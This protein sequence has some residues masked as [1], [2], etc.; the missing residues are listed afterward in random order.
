MTGARVVADDELVWWALTVPIPETGHRVG[1]DRLS[2]ILIALALHANSDRIAWPSAG[3]VGRSLGI[4][5]RTIRGA[6][7]ALESAGLIERAKSHTRSTAW[8]LLAPV[9]RIP[10]TSDTEDVARIPATQP[11]E[12]PARSG[13]GSGG[14]SGGES[15]G[16]PRHEEK[17]REK[18]KRFD[19]IQGG[20]ITAL[21]PAATHML[22]VRPGEHCPPDR[23][24]YLA[25]GSCI[26]CDIRTERGSA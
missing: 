24:R 7:D 5:R 10:A 3:S 2:R 25:D 8:R 13:G 15:G 12:N 26:N 20:K 16:D 19:Q 21:R 4:D 9:A 18:N 11:V 17:R 14:E 22:T 1:E 6:F 23:H